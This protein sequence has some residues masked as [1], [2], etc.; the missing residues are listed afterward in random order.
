MLSCSGSFLQTQN[1]F[2]ALTEGEKTKGQ[3]KRLKNPGCGFSPPDTKKKKD[4]RASLLAPSK[5]L[6][7]VCLEL[8]VGGGGHT[9]QSDF[10]VV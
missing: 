3:K 7:C 9:V 8:G 4:A 6:Y 2:V 5:G 1:G 10:T